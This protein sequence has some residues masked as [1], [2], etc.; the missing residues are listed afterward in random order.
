MPQVVIGIASADRRKQLGL[1]LGQI[2]RQS[3]LP[4]RVVVCP[5]GAGDYDEEDSKLLACPVQVVRATRGLC[6]QRNA[7]LRACTG[8]DILIFIDDDFYPASDYVA[9]V[10]ELFAAYCDVVVATHHPVLDGAAGPGVPHEAAVRALASL[11]QTPP[12]RGTRPIAGAYGCNMALRLAA[13]F[14]NDIWFDENLPLY[15]WL[16]DLDFSHRLARHGRVVECGAL[17]GV[18]LGTKRGR[19]SGVRL[20][21]SQVANPIYMLR[22]GSLSRA[23]A[24]RQILKNMTSNCLRSLK[25]EP[26]VDRRGR[27]KGN[28]LAVADLVNGEL[29]PKKAAT[30]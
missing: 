16:E 14:Q 17:R 30:L 4:S 7:I 5:A 13:V 19:T 1:T 25:P 28:A 26:W 23:Y 27:L 12:L 6:A 20:G 29:H 8:D 3:V 2:A 21:Y 10:L 18:H 22:K 24:F 9:R 15:G 11:E